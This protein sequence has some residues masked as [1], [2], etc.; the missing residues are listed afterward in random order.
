MGK[1]TTDA[2][3][4]FSVAAESLHRGWRTGANGADGVPMRIAPVI[5]AILVPGISLAQVDVWPLELPERYAAW[6]KDGGTAFKVTC[7][8]AT[9]PITGEEVA[10][11]LTVRPNGSRLV[12]PCRE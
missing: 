1:A 3:C 11:R 6:V 2:A 7:G 12:E 10:F 5:I 9:S 4:G 8:P